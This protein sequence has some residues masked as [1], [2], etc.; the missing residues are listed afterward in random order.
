VNPSISRLAASAI[1][2]FK[3]IS[4][5]NLIGETFSDGE[6]PFR[7]LDI[8]SLPSIPR[9]AV[10]YDFPSPQSECVECVLVRES[11]SSFLLEN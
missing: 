4:F 9:R 8:G 11:A 6:I 5:W 3:S 1:G 7:L 10:K 2:E